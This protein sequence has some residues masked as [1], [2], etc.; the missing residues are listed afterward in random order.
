MSSEELTGG[1]LMVFTGGI[2]C[3]SN[4]CAFKIF[5]VSVWTEGN[6]EAFFCVLGTREHNV[7][8]PGQLT[9]AKFVKQKAGFD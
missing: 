3:F 7:P 1:A 4:R 5:S 2:S 8:G 9:S 6:R